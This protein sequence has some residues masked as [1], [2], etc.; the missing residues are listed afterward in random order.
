VGE[1]LLKAS[2]ALLGENLRAWLP[3]NSGVHSVLLSG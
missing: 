3:Y 2:E 1:A